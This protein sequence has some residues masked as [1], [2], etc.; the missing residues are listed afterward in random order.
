MYCTDGYHTVCFQK[1]Y[2]IENGSRKD[3]MILSKQSLVK[4]T[5]IVFTVSLK[6]SLKYFHDGDFTAFSKSA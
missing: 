5:R 1:V 4:N 3:L 6:F 2:Y